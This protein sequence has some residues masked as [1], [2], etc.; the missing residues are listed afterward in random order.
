M[1]RKR[2]PSRKYLWLVAY[3]T[4]SKE[5]RLMCDKYLMPKSYRRASCFYD[6]IWGMWFK[7]GTPVEEAKKYF[8]KALL[9]KRYYNF[10]QGF[11]G[12]KYLVV[13]I[14]RGRDRFWGGKKYTAIEYDYDTLRVVRVYHNY[15]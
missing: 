10:G 3:E 14:F 11:K 7:K 6:D 13:E 8:E 5:T 12:K 4:N 15:Y 2:Y 9:D 1:V